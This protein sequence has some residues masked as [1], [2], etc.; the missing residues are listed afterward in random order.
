MPL[1]YGWLLGI[2]IS[3][4]QRQIN[5]KTECGERLLAAHPLCSRRGLPGIKR[6]LKIPFWKKAGL[7]QLSLD[8]V[9]PDFPKMF[10]QHETFVWI[11]L[12]NKNYTHRA[13]NGLAVN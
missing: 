12:K 10:P 9:C 3:G 11:N 4:A 13:Y 1:D 8:V 5:M 2:S 6:I 7:H